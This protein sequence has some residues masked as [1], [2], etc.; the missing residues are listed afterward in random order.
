[1]SLPHPQFWLVDSFLRHDPDKSKYGPG[2]G[3]TNGSGDITAGAGDD[4]GIPAWDLNGGANGARRRHL[5]EYEHEYEYEYD[6]DEE[7]HEVGRGADTPSDEDGP[8]RRHHPRARG[9]EG[10]ET[11]LVIGDASD[12]DEADDKAPGSAGIPRPPSANEARAR[13]RGPAGGTFALNLDSSRS[14]SPPVP[15]PTSSSSSR[16]KVHSSVPP[17]SKQSSRSS[18][19]LSAA[20]ISK[21]RPGSTAMSQQSSEG[22]HAYPPTGS[23]TLPSIEGQEEEDKPDRQA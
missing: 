19:P 10:E 8:V 15:S 4:S 9:A 5:P 2:R 11:R 3:R 13:R 20:V 23:G 16:S 1:M 14:A 21:G 7:D 12:D 18:S 17:R 6:H 22:G